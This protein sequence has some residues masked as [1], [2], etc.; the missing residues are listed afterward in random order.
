MIS[1]K[2]KRKK[3]A[4]SMFFHAYAATNILVISLSFVM[5]IRYSRQ[6]KQLT[7]ILCPSKRTF[8]PKLMGMPWIPDIW[9]AHWH[10]RPKQFKQM[11]NVLK[12]FQFKQWRKKKHMQKHPFHNKDYCHLHTYQYNLIARALEGRLR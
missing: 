2:P 7:I 8:H 6:T 10:I 5:C 4:K 3:T 1:V 9:I 12:H 11:L